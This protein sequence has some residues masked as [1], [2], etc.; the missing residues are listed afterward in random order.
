[1][2]TTCV[3]VRRRVKRMSAQCHVHSTYYLE[4]QSASASFSADKNASHASAAD[5]GNKHN[6]TLKFSAVSC[7][8]PGCCFEFINH[9]V[10]LLLIL[11]KK[12]KDHN[13][14]IKK[15]LLHL[16]NSQEKTKL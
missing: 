10:L 3:E 16:L 6:Q 4:I 13:M 15:K 14:T 9:E 8:H 1:M 5:Q 7:F 2:P 12:N 11:I